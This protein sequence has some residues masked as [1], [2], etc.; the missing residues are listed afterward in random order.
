MGNRSLNLADN[1]E[2]DHINDVEIHSN[3]SVLCVF[4]HFRRPAGAIRDGYRIYL[5]KRHG[6]YYLSSKINA[7]T[8]QKQPLLDALT[9]CL[10]P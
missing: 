2:L 6:V 4:L 10:Y 9:L 7:S 1:T 5:V 3:R 8:T